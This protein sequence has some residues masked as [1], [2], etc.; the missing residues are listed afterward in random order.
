MET[1]EQKKEEELSDRV[2]RNSLTIK[3]FL[4]RLF[5]TKNDS[6]DTFQILFNLVICMTLL[7]VG[8]IIQNDTDKEVVVEG[9]ITLRY[10]LGLLVLTVVPTWLVPFMIKSSTKLAN[11]QPKNE[12]T[13]DE[14]TES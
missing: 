5:F 3:E 4:Y 14:S 6:L 7:F 12:G 2:Q 13:P 9:L 10:I 11:H 8:Y 1:K